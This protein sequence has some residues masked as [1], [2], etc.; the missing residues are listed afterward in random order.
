MLFVL[1]SK[2]S[3]RFNG[4]GDFPAGLCYPLGCQICL[5]VAKLDY[6]I[7]YNISLKL[8]EALVTKKVAG[9]VDMYNKI[10]KL[11]K[12]LI[13]FHTIIWR[14]EHLLW[15]NSKKSFRYLYPLIKS[16]SLKMYID[17]NLYWKLGSKWVNQKMDQESGKV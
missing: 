4:I 16:K 1:N 13:E 6:C 8:H 17:K 14:R 2:C 3:V 12:Q 9:F 15:S 5:Y 11:I 7:G 10:L